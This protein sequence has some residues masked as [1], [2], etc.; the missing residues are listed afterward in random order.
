MGLFGFA[1]GLGAA[2]VDLD[3]GFQNTAN[4]TPAK[5]SNMS[6]ELSKVTMLVFDEISMVRSDTF[7]M[8]N[9]ICQ[10]AKRNSLPFG[11]IPVVLETASADKRSPGSD[12]NLSLLIVLTSSFEDAI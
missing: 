4:I 2:G 6:Y 12:S 9:Q 8:M 5:A 10:K 11:G 3:E 7:E 1:L